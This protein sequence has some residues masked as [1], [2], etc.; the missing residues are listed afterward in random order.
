MERKS[1]LE[2]SCPRCR[3]SMRSVRSVPPVGSHPELVTFRCGGCDHVETIEHD[4]S[5][6]SA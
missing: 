1:P 5:R 2:L 4:P 3:A 6:H